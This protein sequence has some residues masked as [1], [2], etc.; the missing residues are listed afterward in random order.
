MRKFRDTYLDTAKDLRILD[1][2]S[3]DVNGTYAPLFKNEKWTYHGA[4]MVQGKNVNIL[5]NN[6][7]DWNQI[8]SNSY[9]V[10]I[11][12]QAYEHI[13]Y[14]WITTLQINRVLKVGG[15]ACIIAPASGQEHS[16]P[17]DCWRFYPDGLQTIAKWGKMEVIEAMTQWQSENYE[18]G[19]D[20]W[21]DSMLVC[22]K[23][24]ENH[25]IESVL[26]IMCSWIGLQNSKIEFIKKGLKVI[27]DFPMSVQK[28]F[29]KIQISKILE[30]KKIFPE[31]Y[32]AISYLMLVYSERPDL[33]A[34]FPKVES[35]GELLELFCWA[36]E[37]GVCEDSRLT[38]YVDFYK[39]YCNKT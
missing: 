28:N 21:K 14:F 35:N 31:W 37:F 8:K 3:F 6:P 12:G 10:V 4:D 22:I 33:K 30:N 34:A 32:E 38:P 23:L 20:E 1:I 25:E 11:S 39:K 7:Y 24:T 36:K 9:D 15:M 2:G 19:S 29:V 18:D 13:E 27:K 26:E 16:Y 17:T 5:L